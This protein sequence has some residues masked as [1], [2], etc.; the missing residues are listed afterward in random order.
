MEQ[1]QKKNT[2]SWSGMWIIVVAALALEA[3]SCTMYFTSRAAIRAQAEERAKAELHNA[4][5][6]IELRTI[7]V[8]TVAKAL[9]NYVEKHLDQPD[10]AFAGTRL[11][12]SS[13]RDNTSLAVAFVPDYYP[14][15]GTYYEVCSSRITE[16]SVYTRNIGSAEHDYTQLEWYQNGF[17]HDSC[18]WCEPYLDDSGSET[19]V[20]SC[21]CPVYDKS[22]KVVAVVCV[23]LSLDYLKSLSEHLQVYPNSFSSIRSSKG[24]DIVSHM[25]TMPGR[26]Y[27]IFNEE[28]DATG[29]HIEIII[30]DDVLFKDLNRIGRIVGL[31]MLL[32]LGMLIFIVWHSSRNVKRLF[33]SKALNQRM[34]SELQIAKT[35]QMAMLPKVFPP[36]AD[37]TDINL[38]GLVDPA[39]EIG[40]DLYDFYVRHD[41]LFFCVGDVSGK[42]VPAALVMAM[43]RSLFRSITAHEEQPALIMQ[44]MNKAIVDQNA[45]NMFLT[46]FLGVLDCD[47][48]KLEYCNAGHNAPVMMT[49]GEWKMIDLIPNLPLGIEPSFVYQGQSMDMRYNDLLFLYT[50][51]LTE[52]ENSAHS[53]YGEERMMQKLKGMNPRDLVEYMKAD[54]EAFRGEAEQSDDLTMLAIRYQTPA[55]VMR[56]DIQQIPTLAEWIDGLQLPEMLIMPMNLALEETVSNVMLYAYPG[57][58]GHVYVECVKNKLQDGEQ[59]IFTVTDSGIAFDPTRK[60]EV[61][62]S[63]SA[64]EREIGG[65]GIHLVRQLMDE[66]YYERKENKN[67]LT[68]VKNL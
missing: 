34:E 44:K 24:V 14:G 20:V 43:T 42:G 19:Y 27:N 12:V 8:E 38:Y 60:A 63:L 22:G 35:I 57:K 31:L 36:F 53:Q 47:S 37:R 58:H 15:K 54:V 45:Q 5:L 46:L 65:L 33:E 16:D 32:G 48:G 2:S 51:G 61:D 49:N 50:D 41:K 52:A 56:N 68:L 10:A 26:K 29:W 1:K 66:I 21:S 17:V 55:I 13:L 30:P 18:W 62:T 28:I 11:A 39:K 25:D 67:I 40:G 9:S 23:D 4:E 7:E 64:E 3:I 6:E 59:L